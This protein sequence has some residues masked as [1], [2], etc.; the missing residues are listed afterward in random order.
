MTEWGIPFD[1]IENHWTDRQFAM[2]C[3]RLFERQE[4]SRQR[5]S[6]GKGSKRMRYKAWL[7]D[8][9]VL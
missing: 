9:G 6:K 2:M 3:E 1:H 5:M 4:N 7:Q 8:R